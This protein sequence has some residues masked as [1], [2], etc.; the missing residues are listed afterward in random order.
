VAALLGARLVPRYL[1]GAT[2]GWVLLAGMALTPSVFRVPPVR[3]MGPW[4]LML[5]PLPLSLGVTLLAM[6]SLRL[7][8]GMAT[9]RVQEEGTAPPRGM[10]G[11]WPESWA[12]TEAYQDSSVCG[13]LELERLAGDLAEHLPRSGTVV[14]L[15]L[16]DG[17][18]WHLFGPLA[19]ARPDL[20]LVAL[21]AGCCPAG[22]E[23]CAA[24]LPGALAVSG[25]GALVVPLLPE[26][27]CTTGAVPAGLAPWQQALR[28]LVV[29]ERV[30][31]GTLEVDPMTGA[32]ELC[33]A[34]GGRLPEEPARP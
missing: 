32:A 3:P 9:L 34:L 31:F 24:A 8:E 1:A 26:G 10:I 6:A 5:G 18:A 16:R 12:P 13:A 15:P 4:R 30:W 7:W 20:H 27:R 25:G 22:P 17:R 14:A 11:G 2:L 28:P 29:R 21:T 23:A 33:A 19:V